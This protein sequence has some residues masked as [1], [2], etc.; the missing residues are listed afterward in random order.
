MRP[1][2][3]LLSSVVSVTTSVT[4]TGVDVGKPCLRRRRRPCVRRGRRLDTA[5][6][7]VD[8]ATSASRARS[9]LDAWPSH[10]ASKRRTVVSQ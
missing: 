6:G 9:R 2:R 7:R 1:T 4:V 10:S 3:R 8:A 5:V